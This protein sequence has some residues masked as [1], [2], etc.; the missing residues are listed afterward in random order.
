VIGGAIAIPPNATGA[1]NEW[2]TQ[3]RVLL[4]ARAVALDEVGSFQLSHEPEIGMLGDDSYELKS[5]QLEAGTLYALVAVCDEDCLDIDLVLFDEN[6]NVISSDLDAD[7]MPIVLA[8]PAW[9]GRFVL[10]I[11]MRQCLRA[12]CYYGV[13]VFRAE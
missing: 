6:A 5:L 7:D 10:G 12:P 13:G 9:T 11:S 3:V 8:T 1:V 2:Q 4:L